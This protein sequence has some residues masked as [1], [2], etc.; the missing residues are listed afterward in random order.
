[1]FLKEST[2]SESDNLTKYSSN[3]KNHVAIRFDMELRSNSTQIYKPERNRG[4]LYFC[5][6]NVDP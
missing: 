2:F 6:N 1:M 3:T 4:K 5:W